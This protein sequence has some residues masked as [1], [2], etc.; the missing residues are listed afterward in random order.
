MTSSTPSS[1]RW[2]IILLKIQLFAVCILIGITVFATLFQPA[3]GYEIGNGFF[4]DFVYGFLERMLSVTNTT[5]SPLFLDDSAR[6]IG[7]FS[8]FALFPGLTLF[9][10]NKKMRKLFL[11]GAIFSLLISIGNSAPLGIVMFITILV[12][13]YKKSAKHYFTT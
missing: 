9:A 5:N 1:I 2:I 4:G 7:Y 12:L 10:L 8:S 3:G 11:F 13:A 6:Y